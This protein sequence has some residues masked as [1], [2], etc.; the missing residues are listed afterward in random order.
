MSE[1]SAADTGSPGA[2]LVERLRALP[3]VRHVA[4]SASLA[5]HTTW[6]VG[7][8]AD[9]LC[10]VETVDGLEGATRAAT[11][12]GLPWQVLG[13]GSNVLVADD[14]VEG[15]V[16]LNRAGGLEVEGTTVTADSGLLLSTLARRAARAGLAGIEW[17]AGIPGSVGGAL[18]SNAGA[19]GGCMADSVRLAEIL[20]LAG[21]RQWL[22]AADLQLSYR[23][24]RFRQV[25]A[26]P[27]VVLRVAFDLRPEEPAAVLQRMTVQRRQRQATQPLASASAGSVFKNPPGQSAARLIDEA[28]LKGLSV[29][30][31]TVSILHANFV[32]TSPGGRAADVLALIALVRDRVR[33]RWGV[34]LLLEVQTLGR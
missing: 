9:V 11:L 30:G 26:Q 17:C 32:V 34:D 13:R 3:G 15:L 29:G 20:E 19:H 18:V 22:P 33:E 12:L 8:P 25:E 2:A 6:R 16:V 31:A 28:G 10:V 23:H 5:P 27:A 1:V 14:G 21:G 4:V 7:G 24:S